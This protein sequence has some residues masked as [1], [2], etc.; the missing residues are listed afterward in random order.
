MVPN[1]P[2]VLTHE[3]LLAHLFYDPETGLFTRRSTN[4]ILG[5]INPKGYVTVAVPRTNYL[6][7]RLAWFYMYGE[8]PSKQLD[9]IDRNR[10]NNRI[11]NLR[12]CNQVENQQNVGTLKSNTSGYTGVSWSKLRQKWRAE[13]CHNHKR[14]ILGFFET[15]AAA[16][17]AYQTA[18][19]KLHVFSKTRPEVSKAAAGAVCPSS[20]S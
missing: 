9:H 19:D 15:P 13:L 5:N 10:A 14:V 7:H 2:A 20:C 1:C 4:R 16:A 12:E 18:K 3:T 11:L 17:E 6:A 8:W